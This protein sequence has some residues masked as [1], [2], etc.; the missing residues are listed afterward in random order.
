MFREFFAWKAERFRCDNMVQL[1]WKSSK[2]H[3]G[4]Q[5]SLE[6]PLLLTVSPK[7]TAQND[8]KSLSFPLYCYQLSLSTSKYSTANLQ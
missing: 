5:W 1:K 7:N 3:N 6:E 8:R 4:T 2:Y